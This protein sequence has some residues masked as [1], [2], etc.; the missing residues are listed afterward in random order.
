LEFNG[1]LFLSF[2]DRLS[3]L[4]NDSQRPV[5]AGKIEIKV[6][7]VYESLFSPFGLV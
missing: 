4:K 7:W 2:F 3:A 1:V 5:K 6:R